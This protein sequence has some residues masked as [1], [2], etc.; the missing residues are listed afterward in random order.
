M[1]VCSQASSRSKN[2]VYTAFQQ[3][4]GVLDRGKRVRFPHGTATVIRFIRS[5]RIP[6][7][8]R[9]RIM[10]RVTTLRPGN[11]A[12]LRDEFGS[13]GQMMAARFF[14]CLSSAGL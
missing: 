10:W 11:P 12:C 2:K 7:K 3:N 13:R 8:K 6:T 14:R 9:A 5:A 4:K 1:L